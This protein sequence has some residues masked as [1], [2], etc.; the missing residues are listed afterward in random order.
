[1]TALPPSLSRFSRKC[2]SL[3]VSQP[4]GPPR[5]VIGIPLLFYFTV[6]HCSLLMLILG[7]VS[8]PCIYGQFCRRFGGTRSS[9]LQYR[10]EQ[11]GWVFMYI[12][13]FSP[14]GFKGEACVLVPCSGPTATV[15][16]E[17]TDPPF[18]AFWW[19]WCIIRPWKERLDKFPMSTAPA[20]PNRAT[21]TPLLRFPSW[22]LVYIC[23]RTQLPY[24]LRP[25]R[26]KLHLTPKSLNHYRHLHGAKTQGQNVCHLDLVFFFL[27]KNEWK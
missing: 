2:G 3:Y 10:I 8:A 13:I 4:Y 26:W 24:W 25:W 7:L 5:P 16:K 18:S 17:V 27:M 9:H 21:A 22:S 14:N 20:A 1:M 15:T 23:A 6:G 12:Y 11:D 19:F